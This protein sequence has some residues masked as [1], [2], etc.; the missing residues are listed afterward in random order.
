MRSKKEHSDL[1]ELISFISSEQ[2]ISLKR[3]L[4]EEINPDLIYHAIANELIYVD[5]HTQDLALP[6]N[7]EV[8]TDKASAT[9]Y[10]NF[11][12]FKK[13]K[14]SPN[15]LNLEPGKRLILEDSE[16]NI[17]SITPEKIKLLRVD[18]ENCIDLRI[19]LLEKFVLEGRASGIEEIA[20]INEADLIMNRANSQERD[21]AN[22]RLSIIKPYLEGEP[23]VNLPVNKRTIDNWIAQFR[24][25]ET[26]YGDGYVGLL[27]K[28]SLKGN[29][30]EKIPYETLQIIDEAIEEE[31]R[32][33]KQKRISSVYGA[34]LLKC[35]QLGIHAPSYN[36]VKYRIRKMD[37]QETI[38]K[39]K[40]KRAAYSEEK[41][42]WNLEYTTPRHGQRPFQICHIDH[43]TLDLEL[44]SSEKNINLGRPTLT[45]MIDAYSRRVLV[46][47]L[48]HE[49]PSAISC[50]MALR[51]CV[52]RFGRLPQ[53]IVTDGGPEFRS[54]H[55]ETLLARYGVSKK[56]RPPAKSRFGSV[57]ERIFGTINTEFIYNLAGN[58]QI[59]KDVRKVTKSNNPKNLAVWALP[60][61]F[62]RLCHYAYE[63]YD[64]NPHST[65]GESPRECFEASIRKTGS[66]PQKLIPYTRGFIIDTLPSPKK[67]FVKISYTRGIRVNGIR[68]WS[69]V[70]RE[71]SVENKKV[72][73]RYDPMDVGIAYAYVGGQ[74]IEC[75]SEFYAE[76][77]GRSLKELYLL[78]EEK[79]K[80]RSVS[81]KLKGISLRQVAENT[82][83]I[84]ADE[85]LMIRRLKD[86]EMR[87][88][89]SKIT[90]ELTPKLRL[91]SKDSEAS[92]PA[93]SESKQEPCKKLEIFNDF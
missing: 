84:E 75:I 80:Q 18:G 43:T 38:L 60:L 39:R 27:P 16:Y 63:V 44:V 9:A 76:F 15:V 28:I 62:D 70:F 5:I 10:V 48:S 68:Y 3:L 59:T 31:Y 11:R 50:M 66:R 34:V 49:K 24:S 2:S 64:T 32:T 69:D 25:A 71:P 37:K 6:E 91:V 72:E 22:R 13:E 79:R 40:G 55:F 67:G 56:T 51:I 86:D 92:A 85:K 82:R 74:W 33:K 23:K 1:E 52:H 77:K 26:Q 93:E 4:D 87:K 21:E 58:T 35:R 41:F 57:I 14:T 36:T 81:N 20:G 7:V 73:V 45:C 42:Y 78:S 65:L 89:H 30:K 19:D 12:T 61:L 17:L 88:V 53:L 8:F 29:R 47:Y 83:S 90:E 54:V 46:A